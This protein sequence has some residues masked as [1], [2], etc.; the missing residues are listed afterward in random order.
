MYRTIPLLLVLCLAVLS[1]CLAMP[2]PPTQA[3]IDAADYGPIPENYQQLVKDY[4]HKYLF[5][6]YSAHYENWRGPSKGYNYN[7]QATMY[8]YRVCVD[9]NS[10][11]RMGAYVGAEP[12]YFLINNDKVLLMDNIS[13]FRWC[14]F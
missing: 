14:N 1:G 9:V 13:A 2:K 3:Q 5:D 10:K 11:N 8:G 7:A 4:M 12:F 6:P